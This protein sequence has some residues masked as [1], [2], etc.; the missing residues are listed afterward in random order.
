MHHDQRKERIS[1]P[2]VKPFHSTMVTNQESPNVKL[3]P[4]SVIAI[5]GL[6]LGS[7]SFLIMLEVAKGLIIDCVFRVNVERL[8]QL[9]GFDPEFLRTH[10]SIPVSAQL[11]KCP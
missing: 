3:C 4:G 2:L 7:E 6:F 10:G 8:C 5:E 9:G 1:Q 11:D